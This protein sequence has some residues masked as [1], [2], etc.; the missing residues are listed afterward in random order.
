MATVT[1]GNI[2]F[3][4]KGPYNNAT[5]YVVDDVVSSGGSSYVCIL[6]STGNA[7]SNGTYWQQMSAAGTDGTNG[8]DLTTT[9]TTQG[10]IV[11]RDGSGLQRLAAGTSGQA[12]I[13]GGAG[14]NPSWGTISSDWVKLGKTDLTAVASVSFQD[15]FTADYDIYKIFVSNVA[16]NSTNDLF[17]RYLTSGSTEDSSSNYNAMHDITYREDSTNNRNQATDAQTGSSTHKLSGWGAIGDSGTWSGMNNFELT[18]YDPYH[19][20]KST[21]A[22]GGNSVSVGSYMYHSTY[23]IT[24]RGNQWHN[25]T[26]TAYSGIKFFWNNSANFQAIG[27]ISL[28]GIKA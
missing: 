24:I 26:N 18:L 15:V 10:D 28:Y 21:S 2:K 1:L 9:L 11:Y 6:A 4:W 14:A 13:T 27:T 20:H 3:N 25:S 16:P 7:V 23:Q 5:A 12:L 19:N 8:T 17:F 22:K